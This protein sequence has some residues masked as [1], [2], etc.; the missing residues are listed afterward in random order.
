MNIHQTLRSVEF[1]YNAQRRCP[2]VV[3]ADVSDSMDGA[4]IDELNAGLLAYKEALCSDELASSR[5]EIALVTFGDRPHVHE[6]QVTLGGRT[7]SHPFVTVDAFNPPHLTTDGV[8]AMGA[9]IHQALDLLA[10]RK[11]EYRQHGISY[12][13][14]WV[15]LITDGAPTDEWQSAAR[16]L[17]EEQSQNGFTLFVVAVGD[18]CNMDLLRQ[19]SPRRKPLRLKE[20]N[21]VEFFLWLSQSHQVVSAS[22]PGERVE[23]PERVN[24][25][26]QEDWDSLNS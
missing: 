26:E 25:E 1:A 17:A 19:L 9:A 16:R 24:W 6:S 8:T 18:R 7:E 21:F 10:A 15:V 3:I 2:C 4:P 13:R 5:V 22:M 20:L 11:Q 12:F 23:L 14:P